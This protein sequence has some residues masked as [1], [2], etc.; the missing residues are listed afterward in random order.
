MKLEN[1]VVANRI[2]PNEMVWSSRPLD[3]SINDSETEGPFIG[4]SFDRGRSITGVALAAVRR[5][6]HVRLN[7]LQ[8]ACMN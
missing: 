6:T 3:R 4:W 2:V 7:A 1:E 5:K 8:G